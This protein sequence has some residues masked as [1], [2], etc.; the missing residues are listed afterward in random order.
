KS[1]RELP[2]PLTLPLVV[3]EYQVEVLAWSQPK[4]GIRVV[5]RYR[6]QIPV[7]GL[8]QDTFEPV[9][10]DPAQ[11]LDDPTQRGR[12]GHQLPAGVGLRDAAHLA[13]HR[14]WVV[15]EKCLQGRPLLAD[16]DLNHPARG[17][18]QSRNIKLGH[19]CRQ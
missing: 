8:R 6:R 16:A 5:P 11:M 9:D 13:R 18:W 2:G 12:R 17:R 7:R 19:A 10:L 4:T 15:V 3:G 14:V 1:R